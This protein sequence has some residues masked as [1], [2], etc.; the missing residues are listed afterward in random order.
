MDT[1]PGLLGSILVGPDH[2]EPSHVMALPA[3]STAAQKVEVGQERSAM[4][5]SS[6]LVGP[7]Q[8]EPFHM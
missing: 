2:V 1:I 5:L 7:D 6:M 4:P 8:V 3:S